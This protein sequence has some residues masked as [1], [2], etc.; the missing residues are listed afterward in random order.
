MKFQPVAHSWVALHPEPKGVIQFIGGAF[1]GTFFPMF[2]YRSLLRGVFE[3]GYTIVVLPFN[4]TFDHYAEAGFL[5]K[6]QYE[7]MPESQNSYIL[8][9]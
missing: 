5:I 4:F 6:E 2:F 3:D 1:F 9:I 8:R 7:I